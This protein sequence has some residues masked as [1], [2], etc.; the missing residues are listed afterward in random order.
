MLAALLS[1][2]GAGAALA[3]YATVIERN[4]YAVRR[5]RVPCLPP[6]AVPLRVLSISDLHLLGRQGRKRRYLKGLDRF[7]PDLI[8]GTGDFLGDEDAIDP[9]AETIGGLRARVARLFVL[10]SNDYFGPVPKNPLRYFRARTL[11]IEPTGRPLPWP[12]LVRAL[13]AQGWTLINNRALAVDGID[14]VGLD[15][16]HIGRADLSVASPRR[17]DRFRLAVA[18][19]PD[20][21]PDLAALGY[22]LVVCGHTHGG[23]VRIPGVGALITNSTLPRSMARGLHRIDGAWLFVNAGLG[24]NK[25]APY[26]FACRPEVAVLDLVA[27]DQ[28]S[29]RS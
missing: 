12:D 3:F 20:V 8:I 7:E 11:P 2:V 1:V 9:V 19:S 22:D 25:Y 27:R 13:E 28:P 15:D 18:H 6:D 23:Q 17:D 24:T 10:G 29:T 5:H 26:R 16:A 21:A 14:V 4:W